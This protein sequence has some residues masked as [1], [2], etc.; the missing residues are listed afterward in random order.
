MALK[1]NFVERI[2]S[3]VYS[4]SS[5]ERILLQN[6]F[7]NLFKLSFIFLSIESIH[8]DETKNNCIDFIII[9][10]IRYSSLLMTDVCDFDS[11]AD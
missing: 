4:L 11:F 10:G 1:L 8:C 2:Y 6:Q 9:K 5:Q 3:F 7:L